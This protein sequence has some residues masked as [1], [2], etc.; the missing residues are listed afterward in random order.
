M[1]FKLKDSIAAKVSFMVDGL[2]I[3]Y[4]EFIEYIE[5]IPSKETISR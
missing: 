2:L 4:I 5:D 3:Q 1:F